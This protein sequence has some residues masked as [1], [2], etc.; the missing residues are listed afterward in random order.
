[1]REIRLMPE[2]VAFW[3]EVARRKGSTNTRKRIKRVWRDAARRYAA[4]C[5][6]VPEFRYFDVSHETRERIAEVA[7]MHYWAE[8]NSVYGYS[9]RHPRSKKAKNAVARTAREIASIGLWLLERG[10]H[11]V[12]R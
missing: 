8:L 6:H 5:W 7:M 3:D 4:S 10:S 1:M 11:E 2:Q 9:T 12:E